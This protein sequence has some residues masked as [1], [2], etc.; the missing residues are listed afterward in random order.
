MAVKEVQH[1]LA[2]GRSTKLLPFPLS[3]E[4]TKAEMQLPMTCARGE[5]VSPELIQKAAIVWIRDNQ[6]V[7]VSWSS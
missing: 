3:P 4:P 6:I 5:L 7:V 2:G 1:R